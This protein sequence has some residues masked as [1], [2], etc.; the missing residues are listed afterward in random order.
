M[1]LRVANLDDAAGIRAI[2]NAAVDT[3]ATF[4]LRPRT[5]AESEAW[6][7][8]RSG[9]HAAIVA[10]DDAEVVGFASLSPYRHRPAYSTTVEDSIYVREDQRGKGVGRLLLDELLDV[11]LQ[12]GFH[13]VMARIVAGNEASVAVH[14]AAGFVHIG[15]ERE[16]GR[17]FRTWLDVVCMQR[18]LTDP[19]PDSG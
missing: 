16:V 19:G 13:T 15:V 5:L 2:Y 1:E 3:F 14:R 6:I 8:E 4:D 12:H 17:K 11:A 10:V 7:E 9:A 18:L